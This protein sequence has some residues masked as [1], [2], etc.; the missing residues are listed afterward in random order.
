MLTSLTDNINMRVPV[1]PTVKLI[2]IWNIWNILID[3]LIILFHIL[4]N[5]LINGGAGSGRCKSSAAAAGGSWRTI[6]GRPESLNTC[7]KMMF[8]P[9]NI[10]FF[11]YYGMH[12]YLY[13]EQPLQAA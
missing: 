6:I 4:V 9:L 11:V 2:D 1:S 10:V 12:N 13:Q 7:A 3:V 8:P 5:R